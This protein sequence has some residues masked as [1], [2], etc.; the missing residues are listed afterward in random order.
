[1]FFVFVFCFSFISENF[2]GNCILDVLFHVIALKPFSWIWS[3]LKNNN[4]DSKSVHSTVFFFAYII[5]FG[6]I[7]ASAASLLDPY[8]SYCNLLV[9]LVY[10]FVHIFGITMLLVYKKTVLIIGVAVNHTFSIA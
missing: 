1:M 10:W 8:L 6:Y 5:L 3:Y 4:S 9:S 2:R 7:V